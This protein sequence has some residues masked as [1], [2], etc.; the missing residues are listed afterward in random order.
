MKASISHEGSNNADWKGLHTVSLF[1]MAFNEVVHMWFLFKTAA[2]CLATGNCAHRVGG[3]SCCL[4]RAVSGWY[5]T[6]GWRHHFCTHA[7]VWQT[8]ES[9]ERTILFLTRR[10]THKKKKKKQSRSSALIFQDSLKKQTKDYVLDY[11][12]SYK[13]ELLKKNACA[14]TPLSCS[15][16]VILLLLC[17]VHS[18]W[19]FCPVAM[20]VWMMAMNTENALLPLMSSETSCNWPKRLP[21]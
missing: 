14:H 4:R 7:S 1:S 15:P 21:S 3:T 18:R 16:G 12:Q 10:D 8:A 20:L 13:T 9:P 6:R 11:G 2:C 17:L 5:R 19:L